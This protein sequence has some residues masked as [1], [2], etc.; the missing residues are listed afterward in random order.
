[1]PV[2]IEPHAEPIPGYTLLERLGSGGFGEVWKAE[3]PGG[4]PKAIKFVHGDIEAHDDAE[5]ARAGQEL[6]AMDRVRRVRHAYI[7]SI[8]RYEI[9]E[10]QLIIVTELADRTLW[11]RFKE[12]TREGLR[13]IPREELLNYLTEAAEAL[14]Y[15]NEEYD[16]QHLDIK[17]QNLFLVQKHIKVADFGLAKDLGGRAAATVTGGVTPVYA[18]PET[19]DGWLSR[20]SDQYSLAI[21]Y[22]EVLTG[23]RPFTGGTVR[24]LVMQHLQGNPDLSELPSWDQPAV[25]RALSKDPESRFP[26][27]LDFVKAIREAATHSAGRVVEQ[28][29]PQ[30]GNVLP[31]TGSDSANEQEQNPE[32]TVGAHGKTARTP[33]P[34]HAHTRNWPIVDDRPR[35]LPPR[36][37]LQSDPQ[38]I[39]E[40]PSS[41]GSE[42]DSVKTSFVGRSKPSENDNS[43]PFGVRRPTIVV[44]IGGLGLGVLR[45]LRAWLSREFG[46]E[47]A[48]AQI[49][50]LGI[51]TDAAAIQAATQGQP[52]QAL[53][54]TELVYT[55]L[56]R[57][58]HY[59]KS[60]E[61]NT[62]LS[63]WL[64][65]KLLYRIPRNPDGAGLRA[66]GRLAFVDNYSTLLP[67]IERELQACS[68][69]DSVADAHV[70]V[71]GKEVCLAEVYART[72]TPRVYIV[73]ALGG[74]TG[75]G[76]FLDAAY[77]VRHA[78]RK[79]GHANADVV[80]L[81]LVPTAQREGI[82]S[83]ALAN[84]YAALMEL[85][86]FASN[87]AFSAR[88]DRKAGSKPFSE[89]GPPFQRTLL[90]PLPEPGPGNQDPGE[91]LAKAAQVVYRDLANR[92]GIAS[93]ASRQDRP[94][95][96]EKANY[97]TFHS[98]GL[99]R[100]YWPR[101][102]L[103]VHTAANLCR[104]LVEGW[105]K[106]DA[107]A[108]SADI[109][110][111]TLEQWETLGLRTEALIT[112]H[113]ERCELHLKKTPESLFA[114]ITKPLADLLTRASEAEPVAIEAGPVLEALEKFNLLLG[115]PEELRAP[116]A[117]VP[118]FGA[119]EE[120]L[121]TS[122]SGVWEAKEQ[123]LAE[124]VVKLI[125]RPGFRLAG[126]EECL[127][128][129]SAAAETA[130]QTQE[131]LTKELHERSLQLRQRIIALVETPM[132]P[133]AKPNAFWGFGRKSSTQFTPQPGQELFELLKAYPKCRYQSMTL[134]HVS[135]FYVALRG[136][137]S[138]QIREVD[139]CRHR[140]G[141]LNGLLKD[142]VGDATSSAQ[143]AKSRHEQA[144]LQD[145]CAA[146]KDAVALLEQSISPTEFL[147]FDNKVQRLIVTEH[148]ALVQVCLGPSHM[149]KGLAPLLLREAE[150]FL[151][152]RLQ[153][154]NVAHMFLNQSG[155]DKASLGRALEKAFASATPGLG[156]D[157]GVKENAL[158]VVPAEASG[159]ELEALAK[160]TLPGICAIQSTRTDEILLYRERAP[161]HLSH[162]EQFGA[163]A[164]EAYR[165]RL[166]VD[167]GSLH[168]REDLG[169]MRAASAGE[170]AKR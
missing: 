146:H 50:L 45:Q 158:I 141:E 73:A 107:R 166:A 142:S 23:K 17:P 6:K 96:S 7:L 111:Q 10:N 143:L 106:K 57:P 51:D 80:G 170:F 48:S 3:A 83:T 151:E 81:F 168:S 8:E 102:Q 79:L 138:D 76:M 98:I 22:Q 126:A 42:H 52:E 97:S 78:L 156:Q 127:R 55:K 150:E 18:A 85:N 90:L 44:G 147:E 116:G 93:G 135:R 88:Y 4:I 30:H 65:D 60:R 132:S 154:T 162:L 131:Q 100:I 61:D 94:P 118:D 69:P 159:A 148:G 66:L 46:T 139:F 103:Q 87:Q 160:E 144:L 128:Q 155:A 99:H 37:N 91:T 120:A 28:A 5:G 110:T 35:V 89:T 119:I 149:V 153:G 121:A 95:S 63:S 2:R 13:G 14:D 47:E 33:E 68:E 104:K 122:A 27:C 74:N 164:Q 77:L 58:G 75:S 12:C 36:P 21:V 70:D 67:R 15:M 16:L 114:E 19:F 71:G 39:L 101:R 41:G 20:F 29:A 32:I 84:T 56:Q 115:I 9:I 53:H 129:L 109:R 11:D 124:I 64:S 136:L 31:A 38:V 167:P 134:S 145:G 169:P 117:P 137:L 43:S 54:G 123:K 26:T 163:V 72:P 25:A 161:L 59:L 34:P 82:R 133:G 105:M 92:T 125:E 1:M 140:L 112:E 113:Q 49:H 40:T 62:S 130:L 86:H 165:Q 108:I 157:S 24:Q 152:P